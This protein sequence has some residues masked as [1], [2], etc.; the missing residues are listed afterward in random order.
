MDKNQKFLKRLSDSEFAAVEKTLLKIH[1]G[2]TADLDIKKLSGY[3]DIYRVRTGT[4]RI[5]FLSD[6]SGI[7]ILEIGRRNEKTYKNF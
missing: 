6:E 7:E 5:I 2:E 3:R 1:Q 4:V